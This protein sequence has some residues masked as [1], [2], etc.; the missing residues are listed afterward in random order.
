MAEKNVTLSSQ[1]L[2]FCIR[3]YFWVQNQLGSSW[4]CIDKKVIS[5]LSLAEKVTVGLTVVY[6]FNPIHEENSTHKNSFDRRKCKRTSMLTFFTHFMVIDFPFVFS[7]TSF[8]L[9]F[10]TPVHK[11]GF[12]AFD[13]LPGHLILY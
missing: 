11:W 4:L 6:F 1:F 10:L 3:P 2:L 5:M 8:S 12:L 9:L 7:Y 13:L